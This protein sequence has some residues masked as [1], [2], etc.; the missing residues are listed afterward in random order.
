[1][2]AT[3]MAEIAIMSHSPALEGGRAKQQSDG[4]A[5]HS[6]GSCPKEVSVAL[7]RR[8]VTVAA[9]VVLALALFASGWLVGRL[10]IGA[11]VTPA[12]LNDAERQFMERMRNVSLVGS[13]T[14]AGREDRT[15]QADR[16]D[17]SSVEKVGT[18][19]WRFN[20]KMNC[21]GVNGAIPVVVPMRW[22]GDTPMIMMTDTSLPGLGTFTV[23]LFFYNDRYAGTWQHGNTGGLMSGRIE[24]HSGTAQ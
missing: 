14:V 5:R 23:R 16:Y 24:K 8:M 9:V 2:R 15:P 6:S 22:N 21:C 10:G 20:A 4:R 19:L 13:F 11:V 7:V 1:M 18:D 3:P 12:S 17:I